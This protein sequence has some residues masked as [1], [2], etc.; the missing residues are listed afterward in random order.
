MLGT[1]SQDPVSE[2]LKT[3]MMRFSIE[4]GVH[5]LFRE[6]GN[7]LEVLAI[8]S[9]DKNRGHVREFMLQACRDYEHVKILY[10][11]NPV[12]AEAL[13]RWGFRPFVERQLVAGHLETIE[14]WRHDQ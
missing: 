4:T 3:G 2:L 9:R 10:V 7:T 8:E 1:I 6:T 11:W 12:F 13:D 5:G 14:G